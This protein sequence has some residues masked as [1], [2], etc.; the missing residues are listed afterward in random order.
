VQVGPFGTIVL[1]KGGEI[2]NTFQVNNVEP[3]GV[4]LPESVRRFDVD[5]SK[6]RSLGRY[7]IEANFG[8]G[9]TGQLITAKKTFY[10]VPIPIIILVVLAALALAFLIIVLP[11]M[12]KSYNK[13][14]IRK[15]SRRR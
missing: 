12:I 1:R 10:V 6:V 7:T 11:R 13:R 15:A 5:I 8:Y 3:H 4:V 9:S 2:I 14:V